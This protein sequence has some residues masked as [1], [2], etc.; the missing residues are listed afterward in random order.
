MTSAKLRIAVVQFSP[1]IEQVD[2]NVQKITELT[3]SLRPG[4][5]DL[6]CLPETA[7]TGYYFPSTDAIRPFLEKPR[8]GPTSSLCSSLARRLQC[9]VAAGYPELLDDEASEEIETRIAANSAMLYGPDG[10][11]VANHQKTHL[12]PLDV[13]WARAG[14][15]FTHVKIPASPLSSITLGICM[16]LN[17]K[18]P[19]HWTRRDGPFELACFA[20]EHQTRLV[21]LLCAWMDTQIGPADQPDVETVGYWNARFGPLWD[22][23]S[24]EECDQDKADTIVVVCN[25]TGHERG[26]T[27]AGSSIVMRMNRAERKS[28]IIGVMKRKEEGLKVWNVELRQT[29]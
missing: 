3:Q 8:D 13:P 6:L 24:D 22:R 28:E 17:P 11:L 5:I 16:D 27:F 4:S 29:R 26:I 9:Y 10:E 25:R 14:T 15:G 2:R 23:G 7:L 21:I 18:P 12:F 19:A 1:E 20:K